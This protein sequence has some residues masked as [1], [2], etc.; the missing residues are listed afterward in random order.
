MCEALGSISR[1]STKNHAIQVSSSY[2]I[3]VIPVMMLKVNSKSFHENRIN[4]D[5]FQIPPLHIYLFS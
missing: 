1:T 2:S 4:T 3:Y 5:A